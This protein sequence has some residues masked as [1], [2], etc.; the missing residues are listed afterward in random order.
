MDFTGTNN[1]SHVTLNLPTTCETCHTTTNWLNAKFD[2]TLYGH[3]AL[4][5]AHATVQ[6]A[7]CHTNNN[8]GVLPTTCVSCHQTDYN[9]AMNP[10]HLS[11]ALPVTC[12]NCHNTS[13]WTTATFDHNKT[14]FPLTGAHT[15]VACALCHTKNN[16]GPGLPTACDGCHH[17]LYVSTTSPAHASAGFPTTCETC[18]ST[19]NWTSATFNH[20]STGFALTGFHA[21]MQCAQCHTSA[22]LYAP[23]SLSMTC[24]GCHH[25][26]Y[27]STTSPAHVAAGFPTTC[28]TCHTTTAWTGAVFNHNNTP[29]PL[30]GFHATSV[31]CVQCHINNVFLGTPTDC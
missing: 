27:V 6:C 9:N 10:P 13:S 12:E 25:P 17:P 31:T 20:A 15:T 21:T 5:G 2:H 11:G 18:H 22:A 29:F 4:T 30:T 19:T 8:Y 26:L 28:D 1:P 16:Y 3:W 14:A 7:Q 23:G 24:D